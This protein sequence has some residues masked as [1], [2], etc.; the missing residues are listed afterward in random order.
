LTRVDAVSVLMESRCLT[1]MTRASGV[2]L[3][4]IKGA[5]AAIASQLGKPGIAGG[6]P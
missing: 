1:Y 2:A 6:L 5:H 3:A 4:L